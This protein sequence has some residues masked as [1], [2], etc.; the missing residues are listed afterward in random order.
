MWKKTK[1]MKWKTAKLLWGDLV[2]DI[3]GR[4]CLRHGVYTFAGNA[5]F[6]PAELR[7]YLYC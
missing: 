4:Y 2:Y 1:E 6:A 3:A 5:D 7:E